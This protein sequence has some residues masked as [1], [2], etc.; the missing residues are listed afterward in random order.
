MPDTIRPARRSMRRL[1][2]AGVVTLILGLIISFPARIAYAWFAS[3]AVSLSGISG[4][5][6]RGQ[7]SEG[8]IAGIYVTDLRWRFRPLAL[9]QG[10]AAF[11]VAA[12]PVSG[13]IDADIG[14]G[15]GGSVRLSNVSAALP[16]RSLDRLVAVNGIDGDLRVQLERVILEDGV[17]VDAT[18][19]VDVANLI[20]RPL[21]ASPLGDYRATVATESQTIRGTVED[22]SGVLDVSGDIELSPDRSYSFIGLIAARPEAPA[23]VSDQLQYLGSADAEG[24]RS[25]RLEGQL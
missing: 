2:I 25:F 10:E 23:A 18:G 17:P 3:P 24:R 6:W 22:M 4:S 5:V 20:I 15:F 13:F 19:V 12:Q 14:V 1:V 11:G 8:A 7:A 21:A 9:F 16:I